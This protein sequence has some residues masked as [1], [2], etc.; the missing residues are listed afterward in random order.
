MLQTGTIK[1]ISRY[2]GLNFTEVLNLPYSYF[3]LLSRESWIESYQASSE[4]REILRNL[5][6]LQ[7]TE[8]DENATT[9]FTGRREM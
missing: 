4:G 9:Q 8:A 3:L 2:S 6:R 1:R 5:W 7:Q